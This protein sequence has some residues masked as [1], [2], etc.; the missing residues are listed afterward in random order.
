MARNASRPSRQSLIHARQ[1]FRQG[2]DIIQDQVLNVAVHAFEIAACLLIDGQA[3]GTDPLL[4]RLPKRHSGV[5]QGIFLSILS[6]K[7]APV[8]QQDEQPVP[9]RTAQ[10]FLDGMPDRG[11]VTILLQRRHGRDALADLIA[12]G[13]VEIFQHHEIHLLPALAGKSV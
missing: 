8:T 9:G 1:P 12:P 10:Q 2:Q 13:I 11:P 3:K 5:F 4:P 7:G 6:V